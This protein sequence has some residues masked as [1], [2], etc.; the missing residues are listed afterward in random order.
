MKTQDHLDQ[1][2]EFRQ[3]TG[4]PINSGDDINLKTHSQVILEE[5]EEAADGLQD[6]IVT[7]SGYYHDTSNQDVRKVIL[8]KIAAI[9]KVMAEIGLNEPAIAN[10]VQEANLSKVCSTMDLAKQTKK[11]YHE[12]GVQTYIKDMPDGSFAVFSAEP[13]T[14]KDGK[15]YPA[16][17]L[18]KSVIWKEPDYSNP[19]EWIED[20]EL[21]NILGV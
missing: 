3:A 11:H 12:L 20:E 21:L 16:H 4:L 13:Q 7:M 14:S 10:K 6:C 19:R 2:L 8:D 9:Q 17:K 15:F 18:V 5:F 1:N